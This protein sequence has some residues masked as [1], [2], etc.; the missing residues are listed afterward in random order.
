MI[1]LWALSFVPRFPSRA[2]GLM[3]SAAHS[4][5]AWQPSLL[6]PSCE[7]VPHVHWLLTPGHEGLSPFLPT[8]TG[9]PVQSSLQGWLRP[10]WDCT[11]AQLPPPPPSLPSSSSP[12]RWWSQEPG[13]PMGQQPLCNL[14]AMGLCQPSHLASPPPALLRHAASG[15]SAVALLVSSFIWKSLSVL[16]PS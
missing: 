5:T 7:G 15:L 1:F 4:A 16:C 6:S 11:P 14:H 10:S 2:E 8:L 13:N 12:P 9:H 3:P